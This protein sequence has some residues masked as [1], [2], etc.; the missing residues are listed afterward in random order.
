MVIGGVFIAVL[1][2]VGIY[3]LVDYNS[4]ASRYQRCETEAMKIA[5]E[6]NVPF[7][8]VMAS[9]DHGCGDPPAGSSTAYW[10]GKQYVSGASGTKGQPCS[11]PGS[12]CAEFAHD[13]PP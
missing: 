6:Q 9:S 5:N 4:P 8:L 11:T 12:P 2:G 7:A 1:L 10:D 3:A 13:S